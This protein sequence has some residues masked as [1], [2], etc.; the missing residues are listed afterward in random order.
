MMKK[1]RFPLSQ[2]ACLMLALFSLVAMIYAPGLSGDFLFD[3]FHNIVHNK[4]VHATSLDWAT[5]VRAATAY[6][7]GAIAR[8]LATVTFAIDYY[9]GGAD[10]W[11]YKLVNVLIHALNSLLILALVQRLAGLGQTRYRWTAATCF[12]IAAVWA[13]HPLQVSAVL[14]V[15]QRMEILSLTFVLVGLL[16]YIK[17]RRA[18]VAGAAGWGWLL[19]S[20]ALAGIGLLSKET[21]VLFPLYCLALELTL[22]DFSAQQ[23]RTRQVLVAFYAI[24]SVLAVIA[25][26]FVILPHYWA[27]ESFEGRN[28]TMVERLL[29]QLRVLSMYLGW[30][31]VPATGTMTFYY[32][33]FVP[34]H[35]LLDP[36]STLWGGLLLL[37]LL[38][39]AIASRKRN[40][41][42]ALG[43]LWFFCAHVLTSNVIPLELVF[44]HRNYFALL[45]VV[46]AVASLI[47]R[48]PTP[49]TTAISRT[50][51]AALIASLGFLTVLQ[52]ATWGNTLQLSIDL[53]SRNP[54]SSRAAA[55]LATVYVLLSDDSAQSPFYWLATSELERASKLPYAS[56]MPEQGLILL[57]AATGQPVKDELWTRLIG[58]L[59]TLPIGPQEMQSVSGLL[60]RRENGIE[61]DDRRLGEACSALISR[62]ALHPY[63]YATCANH[64]LTYL[65]DRDGALAMFKLAVEHSAADP[66]YATQIIDTLRDDGHPE[67]AAVLEQGRQAR[68]S[69]APTVPASRS[70][71]VGTSPTSG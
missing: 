70:D 20:F 31:I 47:D 26:V 64:A 69:A 1:F 24:A 14:Y 54:Q 15:V 13:L 41:L 6:E 36:V 37:G 67:M 58:K 5:L 39:A 25:F 7:P 45:G 60:D 9:I 52:T 10:P 46:L 3:D 42:F 65:H 55:D 33:N 22:L 35:G 18:Q 49:T 61:L 56:P 2:S 32:D 8:P 23:R 4:S 34:S 43:M 19:F 66:A 44:E 17:G 50:L 57:A 51:A 30:M 12:V 59:R 11:G 63:I 16:A 29:T 48:I 27:P 40:R 62:R 38:A 68:P 28:Y 71:A 53:A 21:A